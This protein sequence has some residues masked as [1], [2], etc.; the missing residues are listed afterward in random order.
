M[1]LHR[2]TSNKT[3]ERDGNLDLFVAQR[4]DQLFK[5]LSH[6]R[7]LFHC[8]LAS[9]MLSDSFSKGILDLGIEVSGDIRRKALHAGSGVEKAEGAYV[10]VCFQIGNQTD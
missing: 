2:T 4:A 10:V 7:S 9:G 8:L 6:F 1:T 5:A 3:V